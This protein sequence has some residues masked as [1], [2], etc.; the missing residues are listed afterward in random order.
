MQ[1]AAYA[2]EYFE[3]AEGAKMPEARSGGCKGARSRP[4][5]CGRIWRPRRAPRY[6]KQGVSGRS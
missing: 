3:A 5:E 1:E 4:R 2:G 6:Q